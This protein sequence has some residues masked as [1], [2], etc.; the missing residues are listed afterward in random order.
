MLFALPNW[1]SCVT[2]VA[3]MLLYFHSLYYNL[4][5]CCSAGWSSEISPVESFLGRHL[6]VECKEHRRVLV[7]EWVE[8]SLHHKRPQVGHSCAAGRFHWQGIDCFRSELFV[9]NQGSVLDYVF[10]SVVKCSRTNWLYGM[11]LLV[12]ACRLE[13]VYQFTGITSFLCFHINPFSALCRTTYDIRKL[14]RCAI[15]T[16]IDTYTTA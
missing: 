2:S 13:A 1:V 11:N 3:A 6:D 10:L 5:V 14:M 12:H 8:N 7:E 4:S 15:L 16:Y 9:A